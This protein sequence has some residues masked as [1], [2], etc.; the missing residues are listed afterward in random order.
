MPDNTR[1]A[2][3]L[4]GRSQAKPVSRP[5]TPAPRPAAPDPNKALADMTLRQFADLGETMLNEALSEYDFTGRTREQIE[6]AAE[7]VIKAQ[8]FGISDL[9]TPDGRARHRAMVA[10]SLGARRKRG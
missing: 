1:V 4:Y 5:V 6:E 7:A 8:G 9:A 10:Q 2:D 3:R